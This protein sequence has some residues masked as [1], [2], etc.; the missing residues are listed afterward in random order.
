MLC[1][2]TLLFFIFLLEV[3]PAL[4]ILVH[5]QQ[6]SENDVS[7]MY[8]RSFIA[9]SLLCVYGATSQAF[10]VFFA[11]FVTGP[12]HHTATTYIKTS[13]FVAV[14]VPSLQLLTIVTKFDSFQLISLHTVVDFINA[15]STRK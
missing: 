15:L 8:S 12:R 6:R 3:F 14:S 13:F 4:V 10:E 11:H 1:L 2:E 7:E 5:R 9:G